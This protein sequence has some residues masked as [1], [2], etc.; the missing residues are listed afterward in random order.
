MKKLY[1]ELFI[2][3]AAFCAFVFYVEWLLKDVKAPIDHL[4]TEQSQKP[5]AS[6]LITGN[7]HTGVLTD[8]YDTAFLKSSINISL[9]NLEMEDRYKVLQK[10]INGDKIS[11]V[12]L[13]MDPDQLGHPVSSS[14]YDMQL[15][16]YGFALHNNTLSNRFMSRLN[17]FRLHLNVNELIKTLRTGEKGDT[18][19]INFI[20]FTNKARNDTEACKKRAQE[21]SVFTYKKENNNSNLRCIQ[22]IID[23]CKQKNIQLLFL[24]TPKPACYS[25]IYFNENM[26]AATKLIDSIAV[27]NDVLY[28]NYLN[29]NLFTDNDFT[30]YDHLSPAGS[31][32]LFLLLRDHINTPIRINE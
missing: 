16:R 13:G 24:Q 23:F 26:R 18:Q 27:R 15:H 6:V 19:K 10:C 29:N 14:T 7:S 30:D 28:L 4:L 12:I 22:K 31:D 8:A 21:H 11:T 32:K 20:P 1:K 3:A 5:S 25:Q 2:L 17:F 9:S